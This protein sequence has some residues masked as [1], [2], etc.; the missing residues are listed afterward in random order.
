MSAWTEEPV[1]LL[2]LCFPHRSLDLAKAVFIDNVTDGS[3]KKRQRQLGATLCFIELSY[4][5]EFTSSHWDKHRW[6]RQKS[7]TCGR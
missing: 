7:Q 2:L 3:T 5:V 6:P 1:V 4:A